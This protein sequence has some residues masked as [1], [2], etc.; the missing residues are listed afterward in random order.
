M[1]EIRLENKNGKIVG[2]DPETGDEV[3]IEFGDA[4]AESVNTD[5]SRTKS[6]PVYNIK[7]WGAVGDGATDDAPAIKDAVAEATSAGG[8]VLYYPEPD[9][10]Y[11]IDSEIPI[12]DNVAHINP[13][14][15]GARVIAGPNLS[16]NEA[17][18]AKRGKPTDVVFKG[19]EFDA[20]QG[21]DGQAYH[22]SQKAVFIGDTNDSDETTA[23][24]NLLVQDCWVHDTPATALG[25]DS[26]INAWYINNLVEGAGTDGETTGGNGIGVGV[27]QYLGSCP[28]YIIGNTIRDTAEFGIVLETVAYSYRNEDYHIIGNSVTDAR[29]GIGV[30]V[31]RGG[32]VAFNTISTSSRMDYGILFG[33]LDSTVGADQFSVVGNHVKGDGVNQKAIEFRDDTAFCVGYGNTIENGVFANGG[34]FCAVEGFGKEAAGVGS[35][36]TNQGRWEIMRGIEVR[37]T[38]DGT[39]WRLSSAGNWEQVSAGNPQNLSGVS[40]QFVGHVMVDDGTNVSAGPMECRWTGSAWQ[41]S[42]GGATFT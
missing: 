36:P 39:I 2:I 26:V 30:E 19:L 41:P 4:V 42:D 38:D 32:N 35:T 11:L 14:W 10:G 22:P 5:V 31:V 40:G 9:T 29:V 15:A 18:Y 17:M 37:N 27:G 3:P 33:H 25:C 6:E 13:N 21:W 8:G 7:H 24:E 20:S 34:N 1:S 12:E 16:Q 23:P 28:T